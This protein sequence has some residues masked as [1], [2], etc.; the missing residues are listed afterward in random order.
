MT[1][2]GLRIRINFSLLKGVST[3][4]FS[5]LIFGF[6]SAQQAVYT[7]TNKGAIKDY[8]R[9]TKYYDTRENDKAEKE[10]LSALNK[11]ANFIEAYTLLADVYVDQS[12][13]ELAIEQ[14]KKS[15]RH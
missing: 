10:L 3:I 14:Y 11:D 8:E 15:N 12:K 7:S 2:N 5:I 4:L 9:A 13:Y 1:T 6:T